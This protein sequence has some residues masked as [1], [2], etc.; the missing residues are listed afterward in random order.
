[1][2]CCLPGCSFFGDY[3]QLV[4]GLDGVTHAAWSD[5][6]DGASMQVYSQSITW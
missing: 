6:R 4:T 2:T 5:T 3:T 1:M